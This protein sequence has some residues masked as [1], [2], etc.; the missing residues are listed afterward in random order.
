MATLGVDGRLGDG[1]GEE[2]TGG[3]RVTADKGLSDPLSET[4]ATER[5]DRFGFWKLSFS[6]VIGVRESGFNLEIE[7]MCEG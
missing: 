6:W 4:E 5:E 2:D 7:L 3:G 1:E